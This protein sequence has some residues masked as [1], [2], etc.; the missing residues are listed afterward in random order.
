M[1][2]FMNFGIVF[3][4]CAKVDKS[5]AVTGVTGFFALDILKN[6][7]SQDMAFSLKVHLGIY[8][9]YLL[10]SHAVVSINQPLLSY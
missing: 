10:I 4:D 2:V 1:A 6:N 9:F 8:Y 3:S 5:G 7:A